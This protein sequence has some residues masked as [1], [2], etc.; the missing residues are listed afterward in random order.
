[1]SQ[2]RRAW[3]RDSRATRSRSRGVAR[4][5]RWSARGRLSTALGLRTRHSG[6]P[7][8][9]LWGCPA[10]GEAPG[11][12]LGAWVPGQAAGVGRSLPGTGGCRARPPGAVEP[13]GPHSLAARP[14][15]Q[16]VARGRSPPPRWRR[17]CAAARRLAAPGIFGGGYASGEGRHPWPTTIHPR[18]P[19][20]P[21]PAHG[22]A[23]GAWAG[24]RSPSPRRA[25][26]GASRPAVPCSPPR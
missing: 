23:P 3:R 26:S 13:L 4:W 21:G 18:D 20:H 17:R 25:R 19:L 22:E 6:G 9:S 14:R 5:P 2:Q 24:A 11:L 1:M 15:S 16:A 8:R 7:W 12:R 10:R